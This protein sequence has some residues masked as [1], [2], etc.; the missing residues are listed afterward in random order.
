MHKKNILI[1]THGFYPE[2]SPRAFRATELAKEFCRQGHQVTVVAPERANMQ[3][4]L[5]KFT[6]EFISL[7][8]LTWKIPTLKGLGKLK[9]LFNKATNR[10]F[11]LLLAFPDMELFYKIKNRF[12]SHNK[13]YDLVISIAVPYPIHWGVAAIWSEDKNE[14]LAPI[15]IA[16]CGD[17]YCLQEN[18]TFQPP[19]YFRW[20]E[21]WFMK[22]VDYVSV[23]TESSYKGYFDAFHSKIQVIPQ[24]FRFEDIKKKPMVN[25]GI[26]RFGYGGAFI[27]GRRDPRE[28]LDF[29]SALD[30]SVRYEFHI[31]STATHLVDA[32]ATKDARIKTHK[33]ISRTTLLETLSTFNFVVNFANVGTAQTPSKLIDYIIIEKPILHIETGNLDTEAV[34]QFLNANYTKQLAIVNP[35]RFKITTVANQFLN[36]S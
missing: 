7:G 15:W 1:V 10:L 21:H 26:I 27:Q 25:D 29:L 35:N 34:L 16:D 5:E 9:T 33:P 30:V 2:Q 22:K 31:F 24:G 13:K 8:K 6:I 19:F 36:L 12:K 4:L 32:Y 20:I 28:L 18:D 23:P 17:P 3:P 11:P 14:N